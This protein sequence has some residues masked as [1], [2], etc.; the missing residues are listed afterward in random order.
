[1][2]QRLGKNLD[3]TLEWKERRKHNAAAAAASSVS[4]EIDKGNLRKRNSPDGSSAAATR[5]SLGEMAKVAD[6]MKQKLEQAK[7]GEVKLK[8]IQKE[9]FEKFIARYEELKSKGE[10]S[11]QTSVSDPANAEKLDW[12]KKNRHRMEFK[13]TRGLVLGKTREERE[14]VA[15][16]LRM[17][18]ADHESGVNLMDDQFYTF[19]KNALLR[20]DKANHPELIKPADKLGNKLKQT[21]ESDASAAAADDDEEEEDEEEGSD[22]NEANADEAIVSDGK[23]AEADDPETFEAPPRKETLN[24]SD[25]VPESGVIVHGEE[26]KRRGA[27]ENPKTKEEK[28]RYRDQQAGKKVTKTLHDEGEGKSD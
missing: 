25:D 6:N 10:S 13:E 2:N 7:R 8:D 5:L 1:M 16:H 21:E 20:Y 9:R 4:S 23:T 22:D 11:P 15:K 14:E 3:L 18:L 19:K 17:E 12:Y 24:E 27:D 28:D 26:V